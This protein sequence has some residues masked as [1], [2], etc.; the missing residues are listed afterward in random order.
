MTFLDKIA[1]N[2]YKFRERNAFCIKERFF[3]YGELNKLCCEIVDL[4]KKNVDGKQNTVGVITND[5]L[6]TYAS[7]LAL[8]FTGNI[9]V[10]INPRN[11][12]ARN[13]DI[14]KQAGINT[15]L[16]T[17]RTISDLFKSQSLKVL[18][19]KNLKSGPEILYKNDQ[20]SKNHR[21]SKN[22]READNIL[23]LLFTSG[24]TGKPKGVPIGFRNLDS[25]VN[26]FISYGY[27]FTTDDRFLQLYDLSFDASVR[28]YTVPLVVGG[29]IYTVP[30]DEIKYLYALKLMTKHE[31]T[32][33]EMPPSTL[34]YL[35]SYFKSIRL[36]KIRYCLLG[37]E[38]LDQQL[39]V[40]WSECVPNARIQNIYGPTEATI[41][42]FIY[43]WDKNRSDKQFNGI[44][45]I[46]KPF[47]ANLAMVAD[48]NHNRVKR[49]VMGELYVAGP[50]ITPGYW[51][52][53]EKNNE[54]FV[55]LD[56]D[57]IQERFYRTGDLAIID[58]EG[59]FLFCGR[60]DEQ[61]QVDGFRVELGEIEHHAREFLKT[62][63]VAVTSV[64]SSKMTVEIHLFVE[65]IHA[66]IPGL[67]LYLESRLPSYMQPF[68]IHKIKEFPKSA[69]GKVNKQEL[70]R[71]LNSEF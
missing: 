2:F 19:T 41:N 65:D 21:A 66:D 45:S 27:E 24:S 56:I 46:G 3:T 26:A 37:G 29:C 39:V 62:V 55:V 57:G 9:I 31:L 16:T 25:F 20:I 70:R 13:A 15:V 11:P 23:Y 40:A 52:N 30:Q 32:I 14:I 54:A 35:R 49:D 12:D 8:W 63:N 6:E 60:K 51:N 34:L 33:V 22:N 38:A 71:I 50:Q 59:D 64:R 48:D 47:G 44:V 10:P 68:K 69:G 5:D 67:K 17:E 1:E 18:K 4:I 43:N 42:C 53:Q 36:G 7:V 28:W 61:V 58:S